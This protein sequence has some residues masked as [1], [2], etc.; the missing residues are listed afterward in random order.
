M[1]LNH[2]NNH[3]KNNNDNNNNEVSKYDKNMINSNY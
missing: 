1:L 2:N 3:D